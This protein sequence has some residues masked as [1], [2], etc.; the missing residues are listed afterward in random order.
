MNTL[1]VILITTVLI[2]ADAILGHYLSIAA[3][4][5]TFVIAGII[6]YLSAKFNTPVWLCML[7][8]IAPI[9]VTDITIKLTNNGNDFEAAGLTNLFF[10][11]NVVVSTIIILSVLI[12]YHKQ[13]TIYIISSSLIM[14]A[15]AYAHLS[16]FDF[17][18]LTE[19]TNASA[20][21]AISIK[22]NIF[23]GDL[24]FSDKQIIYKSDTLKI[25]DGW[26]EKQVIVDHTHLIK[27]YNIDSSIN[28]VVH[29]KSNK[30]FKDLQIYYKVN[31]GDINGSNPADSFL[32]FSDVRSAP[33]PLI[34]FFKLNHIIKNS[35]TIKQI[36][37]VPPFKNY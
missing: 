16:Y 11:F 37:I 19:N 15:I 26:C 5:F 8:V 27:K 13:K 24:I 36:S 23:I 28:Y 3:L 2:I 34:T 4:I 25:I 12:K 17:L 7:L 10:I 18:G 30:K 29:L 32:T 9:L 22:N 14:L 35:T 20:T 31:D 6:A 21:K 33:Q 1:K